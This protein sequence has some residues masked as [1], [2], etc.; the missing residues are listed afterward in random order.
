MSSVVTKLNP[1]AHGVLFVKYASILLQAISI[2]VDEAFL[3][4][5]LDFSKLQG[6]SWEEEPERCV[7]VTKGVTH[8]L[9]SA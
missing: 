4:A 7:V 2:E 6:A 3:Y 5:M 9:T 1:L 8:E